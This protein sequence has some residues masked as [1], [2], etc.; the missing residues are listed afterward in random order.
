MSSGLTE[1]QRE[2]IQR[3]VEANRNNYSLEEQ[4]VSLL[5]DIDEEINI[6]DEDSVLTELGRN[7]EQF[8][9]ELLSRE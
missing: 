6:H 7:V 2:T 9:D 4:K 1:H 5:A 8:L 3:I